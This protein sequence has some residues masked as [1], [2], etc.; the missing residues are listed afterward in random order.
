[1]DEA[2]IGLL[3]VR[4]VFNAV[5]LVCSLFVLISILIFG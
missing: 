2:E 3:V 4:T 5:S 1:M